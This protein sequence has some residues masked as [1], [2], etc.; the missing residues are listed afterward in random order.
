MGEKCRFYV[1]V[2]S[3][4]P[5]TVTGSH[6]LVTVSYPD[7]NKE[8]LLV[9]FGLYQG[10][11][12]LEALNSKI[13]FNPE[14]LKAIILTHAHVDHCGRIPMLYK[15]GANCRTLMTNDTLK[16]SE[17]LLR[18][19]EA[20]IAGWQDMDPIYD[21]KNLERAI[22]EFRACEYGEFIE[23]SSHI[24]IMFI[25]NQHIQG[26]A[27][28]YMVFSYEG[29]EDITMLFSG[30]Y[31][32]ENLFSE[33]RTNIPYEILEKPLSML[34]L[35]STYGSR[36][37]AD[38]EYGKFKREIVELIKEKKTII[39]PAFAYGRYQTI[40]YLLKQLE[41]EGLLEDVPIFMDGGLGLELTYSWQYLES[42]E[43]KDFI[44]KRAI[45][46]NDKKQVTSLRMPKIV[47]T[48]S[49]MGN[50]GPAREYIPF[51][52]SE[53]YVAIYLT[54]YASPES[55]SRKILEAE[56]GEIIKVSGIMK[57][58]HAVVKSTGEFS[59]HAR[60]ED[61]IDLV[62]QFK[63]INM[64]L[65]NHGDEEAETSLS[66]ECY[67]LPNVKDVGI[68]DG[69]TNFRINCFGLVKTLSVK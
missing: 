20:I 64:V 27:S 60:K 2:Q 42:V 65:L 29:E 26:A 8:T 62:K 61:L 10:T 30:D 63:K 54:G 55:N 17:K 56:E 53:K 38:V 43:I 37:K 69:R 35:E 16:V 9:D 44:P 28:V 13:G 22:K 6:S 18:N 19:T 49:G 31:N 14:K 58:K 23:I 36:K 12:E 32:L 45:P 1:D 33:Y 7:G 24:K 46:V 40:L 5:N 51:Y 41:D 34:M 57:E 15:H 59:S 21:W 3:R 50:F 52:I 66:K 39:I 47:V 48:T 4:Q 68:V 25:R 67:M 11:K